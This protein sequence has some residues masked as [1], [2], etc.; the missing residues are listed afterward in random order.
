M[1][2]GYFL[3]DYQGISAVGQSFLLLDA[4]AGG[5]ANSSDVVFVKVGP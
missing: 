4:V 1:A 2:R 3:G 5:S